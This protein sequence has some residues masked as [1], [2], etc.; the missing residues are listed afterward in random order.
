MNNIFENLN[1]IGAVLA[2]VYGIYSGTRPM[3]KLRTHQRFLF[4][5]GCGFAVVGSVM[6]LFGISIPDPISSFFVVGTSYFLAAWLTRYAA[7][8]MK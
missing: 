5:F 3:E 6:L 1:A 8:R 7:E 2:V 4:M